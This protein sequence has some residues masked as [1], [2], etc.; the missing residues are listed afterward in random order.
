MT[1]DNEDSEHHDMEEVDIP[2][3]PS[4]LKGKGKALFPGGGQT[5]NGEVFSSANGKGKGK[6]V[7]KLRKQR[8]QGRRLGSAKTSGLSV[9]YVIL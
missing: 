8:P 4:D 3:M 9:C 2:T 7:I 5:L 1:G 6:A